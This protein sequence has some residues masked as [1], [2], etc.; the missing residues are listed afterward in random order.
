MEFIDLARQQRKIR[1][2]LMRR[3]EQV[4]D[5]GK[6]IMGPEVSELEEELRARTGANNVVSCASG[7]DALVLILRAAGIGPGDAV[8]VPAFTFVA[9][10]EAVVTVG[11]MPIFIDVD[12]R[13][14]N[15]D[16]DHLSQQLDLV[17]RG[18]RVS[19]GTPDRLRPKA[20]IAVDLFGLPADYDRLVPLCRT[21]ELLL[22][23]D[24]AQSFGASVH[25]QSPLGFLQFAA[26]SFFPAKPL[27][28]FGD[29]GA[30]FCADDESAGVMRSLRVHG[31]GIDK[32]DNVQHGYNSRLDTIQAAIL[33]EKLGIFD[34]ELLAKRELSS[35]YTT[36]L[37]KLSPALVVPT[38][39]A[40]TESACALYTIR[41]QNR[42]RF[43][44]SLSQAGVPTF[45][46]YRTGLH[47]QSAYSDLTYAAGSLPV[48][49]RLCQ[50]VV[51][52]PMHAYLTVEERDLVV[53]T[54]ENAL[55][56]AT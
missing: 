45:V 52:L 34:E 13:T 54:V 47:L 38:T 50:E 1:A 32:Y 15:L 23:G 51:S 42:S 24:G 35:F 53:S 21:Q 37:G 4:L 31:Q 30:V 6:Y 43:C 2:N 9:T 56:T 28:G 55:S 46:Y 8:F 49:E 5:H 20:V 7:T 3:I 18:E 33:L 10:A 39:G 14:Y 44:E 17:R 12:E 29:G 25:G 16:V 11:A 36:H 22:I 41:V 19:P 27:G 26:T 48:T 40:G